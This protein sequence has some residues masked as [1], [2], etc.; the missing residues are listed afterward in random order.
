MTACVVVIFYL[1]STS[2]VLQAAE[3]I[4]P[5]TVRFD[6]LTQKLVQQLYTGPGGIAPVWNEG[7]CRYLSLDHP[8]FSRQE[9]HLRFTTHGTGNFGTEVLGKCLSPL[10]WGGF[11]EVLI[12]PS[13]T[14]DWQLHLR[15]LESNL[16][17]EEWK[18]GLLTGLLWEVT[19]RAF[20][21]HLTSLTIDLTPPRD[22][23]LFL[24]RTAV[25]S[26]EAAQV[27]AI[28]HSASAKAI[29][30]HDTAVVVPLALTVPDGFVQMPPLPAQP[31]A[32]LSAAELA[33]VQ[34][35]LE[36]WDAFLVFVIKGVGT[37]VV[38]PHIREELFDLLLTSRY[39]LLPVL[40]GEVT[41]SEGDPLRRLF[42][43][44]WKRLHD[45]IQEAEQR[46]LL[47]DKILRYAGFISAGD[48]LMVLDQAA[49]GLGI[50][51][52]ADGLRRLAR[53]L[54]PDAAEDPLL[55][56]LDADPT[57]RILF[58]LSPE[59]P[60]EPPPEVP[61]PSAPHSR[62]GWLAVAY[63]ATGEQGEL[64]T[65]KERLAH[66]V[67]EESE[68]A[69]YCPVMA[70]LLRLTTDQALQDASLE[71]RYVPLC[72]NLMLATALQESC[73]RQFERDGEKIIPYT[74]SVGSIGLMQINQY[75]WRG[76]YDVERLK[77]N[78]AYNA[79]AGAE[80]LLHYLQQ[81]GIAEEK[82]TGNLDNA[83]RATYAVYNAGPKAVTRYR[84]QNSS[85]REKKVDTRFRKLYRGFAADGE[86][87][88]S[89]CTV[90][91]GARK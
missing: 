65:L 47:G 83:A 10:N 26:S 29:E 67:P 71:A 86:V 33:A 89:R 21:P 15:I 11:I 45:I 32:P 2:L 36:R 8:Q 77:W 27:E 31:E 24:V 54:R 22:D 34:Q 55:Y 49:P 63:A 23:V 1:G 62:L 14:A 20:L 60:P 16:Y 37:D 66:W 7:D 90:E 64:T 56:S 50:E 35:A 78:A 72:R 79:G 19:E 12:M 3:I 38:D 53:M 70:Q 69:D 40:A 61:P 28:L 17:D 80:I 91:R 42:I 75:V 82:Q 46:G 30:T 51:I 5:L 9:A 4:I 41:R 76:F 57:L 44:S 88:L 73:W 59:L 48:A 52:S 74:S 68:F 58:G 43:E 81:Y 6:L 84:A 18:K 39:A 85:A 13:V 25:P 87:D